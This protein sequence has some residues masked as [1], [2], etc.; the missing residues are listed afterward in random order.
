MLKFRLA[1][2]LLVVSLLIGLLPAFPSGLVHALGTTYYVAT[3]GNDSWS[4]TLG[5]P[6]L[7]IQKCASVAVAGDTCIIRAGTY[8]E[9][10]TPTNSGTASNRIVYRPYTGESVTIDGANLI[11]GWTLDSGTTYKATVTSPTGLLAN[12]VFVD[13][14]MMNE[15]RWPNISTTFADNFDLTKFATAGNGTTATTVC[16]TNLN[17]F[18]TNYWVGGR[19]NIIPG[20]RWFAQTGSIT[21]SGSGSPCPGGSGYVTFNALL[22]TGVNYDPK[23]GDKYYLYGVQAGLDGG[24]EWF[25]NS[26]TSTLYLKTVSGDNPSGHTVRMKKRNH[27]FDLSNRS[28][29]TIK[30]FNL[31]A[32]SILTNNSSSN[33]S[34]DGINA[35]YVSHYMVIGDDGKIGQESHDNDTGIILNGS[36]NILRNSTI[37]YSAGNGVS[38]ADASNNQV[39]NNL[40]H[41]VNYS[42]TYNNAIRVLKLGSTESSNILIKGNSIY[43]TGR[44]GLMFSFQNSSIVYN[45]IYNTGYL[46]QDTGVIYTGGQHGGASHNVVAYNRFHDNKALYLPQGIYFDEAAT[47]FLAH[48]NVVYNTGNSLRLNGGDCCN[49]PTS[50]N[51]NLIYNNTFA[52][53]SN[54]AT[55]AADNMNGNILANNIFRGTVTTAP[56]ATLSNNLN[57][58]TD[59]LFVNVGANNYHIQSTSPA[60]DA[61][62]VVSG[63]T[64]G[65]VGSAPDIGAYEYGGTDWTAGYAAP[66]SES[67]DTPDNNA[68]SNILGNSIN[69]SWNAVSGATGYKVK[70]GTSSGIYTNSVDVGNV[71]NS[72]ITGLSSGI[73]YYFAVTSYNASG[74]STPSFEQSA[75]TLSSYYNDNV[76]GTGQNQ[77]NYTGTWYSENNSN[78]SYGTVRYSSTTN[79]YVTF[80]FT[81]TQIKWYSDPGTNGGIAAVSIDNGAETTVDLYSSASPRPWNTVMYTSPALS[82]GTHTLKIRVTGT[83]NASSSDKWIFIDGVEVITSGTS[84]AI[85]GKVEAENYS[86]MSGIQTEATTDTGGGLN[87]GYV[88]LGDWM[89]YSVNVATTGSYTVEYRV[90]SIN[91]TGQM[92]LKS[93]ATTLATTNVPNTGGWQAWTTVTATV[94]LNAGVQTLRVY[95][96]SAGFNL[97]WLNFTSATPVNLALNKTYTSSV[98][99]SGTYPDTSGTE[100]T[101]GTYGTTSYLNAPWQGRFNLTTYS[102]TIDLG[103]SQS[104]S[105]FQADFLRDDSV[106]IDLPT[107]VVYSTSTDNITF[108]TVGTVNTPSSSSP[109]SVVYQLTSAATGRYVKVVI[110]GLWSGTWVFIDEVKVIQ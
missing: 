36:N 57:S 39:V 63:V 18:A 12:Q 69:V 56:G 71:T 77:F 4:G 14:I 101:D 50:N 20:S 67:P 38:I 33:N 5:A 43:N 51:N 85:P 83:K 27:A 53:S 3:N 45:D 13:G 107:S 91:A 72:T 88:D 64:D 92:Q 55:Y 29:T 65:Y 58:G 42:A 16:D 66:I 86:A 40:I 109:S 96:S 94:N 81:G 31:L 87:V 25:Y 76:T 26:G 97:N 19:I 11:T 102:Y 52:D 30:G 100:L 22:S 78:A 95:A 34:I 7:T 84:Y 49:L 44:D 68:L 9:A 23:S 70:Y 99:A 6:F 54:V 80:T 32:T 110:N 46:T 15:A 74:E 98:A 108:T 75:T 28:Y 82:N 24:G 89:D 59:P 61:G 8:R 106:A 10:I 1:S 37:A 79:D 47:P 41:D 90:A 93:G 104:I 21:A 2:F 73:K 62:M 17:G 48:H 35:Q 103:S 105:Q 60:K